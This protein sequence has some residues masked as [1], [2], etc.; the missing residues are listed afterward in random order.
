MLVPRTVTISSSFKAFGFREGLSGGTDV[1]VT[2]DV[3]PG[4]TIADLQKE[5]VRQKF[6]LDTMAMRAELGKGM[7]PLELF[8]DLYKRAKK[9]S[10][11]SINGYDSKS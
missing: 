10:E 5:I 1:S 4:F 2:L 11:V 3:P 9:A 6:M 8:E 7:L